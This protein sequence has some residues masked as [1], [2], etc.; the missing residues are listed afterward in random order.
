MYTQVRVPLETSVVIFEL[1]DGT[2]LWQLPF[3]GYAMFVTQ[4]DGSGKQPSGTI[5][6]LAADGST[7]DQWELSD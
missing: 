1:N 2:T 3:A 4:D 6:A 5:T 7:I